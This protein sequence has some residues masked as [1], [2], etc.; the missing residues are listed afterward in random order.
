MCR[1]EIKGMGTKKGERGL[2]LRKNSLGTGV[3]F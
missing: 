3:N 1:K 2:E